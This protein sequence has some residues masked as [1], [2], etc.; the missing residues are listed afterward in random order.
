[1]RITAVSFA[2]ILL[3]SL[4]QRAY[5][6]APGK[7]TVET[8]RKLQ[9]P[10]VI[11]SAIGVTRNE[12]EITCFVTQEDFDLHTPKTRI[13][14]IGG[15]D[16]TGES[17]QAT[18]AALKWFCTSDAAA[19]LR[20]Q[21]LVSA[22]PCINP[23]GIAAGK[24]PA[25]LSGGN[26]NT[27]FPPKVQFYG[28]AKTP[29]A[30]YLWRW[31]K[32][33]VPDLVV[34]V[35]HGEKLNWQSP[36]SFSAPWAPLHGTLGTQIL[37]D[38]TTL[39]S[40]LYGLQVDVPKGGEFLAKLLRAMQQARYKGPL[41]ARQQ[42]QK[43]VSRSPQLVG[44]NLATVYGK[45]LS[46]VTY[47]PALAV[48]ARMRLGPERYVEDARTAVQPYFRGERSAKPGSPVSLA[49]HLVFAELARATDDPDERNRYTELVRAA[50]DLAFD[51]DGNLDL[52]RLSSSKMSDAVFMAGP[53]LASAG[54]LTGEKRYFDACA[55][56]VRNMRKLVRRDDGLYR[57]WPGVEAAWGRGNG[58]PALGLAL[59]LSDFPKTHPAH[60]ELIDGYREHMAALAKHQ[61]PTGCWHQIIDRPGSYRELTCTCMIGFAMLR[62]IRRDWL[63][64]EKFKPA[65]DRAWY[66]VKQRVWHGGELVDVC[67]GTGKQKN[68]RAY[69]D[70]KAI[71]GRDAR[72]G[73]MA[74]LF[75]SE[76]L[77]AGRD[78]SANEKK[79][80]GESKNGAAGN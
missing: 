1:M 41:H 47:I 14:L 6:D 29:E 2:A 50:A 18:V 8:V 39:A 24:G 32:L 48:L 34:D 43:L 4:S 42:A 40:V 78:A 75:A 61:D 38:E 77:I 35:R 67:T 26:P 63:P 5:C 53:I 33:H 16:G 56:H 3:L 70:R 13:L 73:A 72:G 25:N 37:K 23:D 7:T 31:I 22:V 12:T 36:V 80:K 28:D 20:K 46:S 55:A 59:C 60:G 69:Y 49:G 10:G 54:G 58:F 27:G 19:D 68:L 15:L 76:V 30:A 17:V 71:H 45:Q 64:A 62:G 79:A 9:L 57:H 52:A 44:S 21:F 74:L 66:A 65:V 11:R 51:G